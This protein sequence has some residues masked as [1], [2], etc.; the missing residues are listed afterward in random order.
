LGKIPYFKQGETKMKSTLRPTLLA[1]CLVVC[2]APLL[3]GQTPVTVYPNPIQFGTAPLNSASYPLYVYVENAT[4]TAVDITGISISGT[5]SGDF[6]VTSPAWV[7][8][9]PGGSYCEMIMTF[10]PSVMGAVSAK[11][12]IS[13]SGVTSPETFTLEGTGGNPI[14]V[15][16]SISP[17]NIYENSPTM[18][19]ARR[20]RARSRAQVFFPRRQRLCSLTPTP[21][22]L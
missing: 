12:L 2:S 11:L 14:P 10:T 9:I 5:Y 18:R 1:A 17:D 15:I 19:T 3:L 6:T 16:T 13:V 22:R 8:T 7:G 20:Q 4:T 21:L